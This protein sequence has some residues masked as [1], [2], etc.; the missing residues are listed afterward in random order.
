MKAY[1]VYDTRFGNTK[2]VAESLAK[3]LAE[4]GVD[5]ACASTRETDSDI[6][7]G[8]GLVCLG[9]P[10]EAFS[11]SQPMK[12]F[13]R[14]MTGASLAGK[15]VFAFDTKVDW[16][17]SG[18]AAKY[19]EKELGSMGLS[20]AL[21]RESAIVSTVRQGG[22]IQGAVLREGELARF[23]EIGRRLGKTVLTG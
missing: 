7:N 12:E 14:S 3:G 15:K 11:A 1:V 23:E 22:S 6:L 18:S 9:A 4:S 19:I 21:P 17:M 8:S 2:K 10:T 16:R 5:S 20:P 13:L